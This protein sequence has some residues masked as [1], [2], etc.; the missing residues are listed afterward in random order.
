MVLK[1]FNIREMIE[2]EANKRKIAGLYHFIVFNSSIG[3][4]S[5]GATN[6]RGRNSH[7]DK[8]KL[9]FF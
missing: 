4:F 8:K 7:V 6:V 2:K 9:A 5:F 1:Y 3:F